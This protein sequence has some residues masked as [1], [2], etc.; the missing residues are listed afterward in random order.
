M[1]DIEKI[2]DEA[3]KMEPAFELR[4][5]FKD[6]VLSAIKRSEKVSQ[7]KLYFWMLAGTMTIF[8]FG[9]ATI[10]YFLPNLLGSFNSMNGTIPNLTPIAVLV[11]VLI[12]VIQYLDKRLVKNKLAV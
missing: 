3:L 9:Y 7:R 5:D 2:I 12:A 1:K 8:G 4:K 6:K 11:G 10:S